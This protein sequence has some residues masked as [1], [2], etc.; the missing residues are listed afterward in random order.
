MKKNGLAN[1]DDETKINAIASMI[2]QINT[3]YYDWIPEWMYDGKDYFSGET[4]GTT[5]MYPWKQST[6]D[7]ASYSD[8]TG[9]SIRPVII[10]P[11]SEI[12]Q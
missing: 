2:N 12:S 9:Y 3:E 7:G 1:A 5:L 6:D 8:S 11:I 10:I 4:V